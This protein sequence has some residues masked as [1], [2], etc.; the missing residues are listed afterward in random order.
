MLVMLLLR[1]GRSHQGLE[2]MVGLAAGAK[3]V[4]GEI[5]DGVATTKFTAMLTTDALTKNLPAAQAAD[6]KKLMGA[7][8]NLPASVWSTS[9]TECAVSMSPSGCSGRQ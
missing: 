7:A 4:G 9:K 6:V 5:I 3:P 2:M 1:K 8:Q